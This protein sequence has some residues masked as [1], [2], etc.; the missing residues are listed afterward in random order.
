MKEKEEKTLT[1]AE[2]EIL[3]AVRSLAYGEVTVTVHDRK[4]VYVEVKQK[5]KV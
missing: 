4:P 2:E 3:R 5:I 1:P